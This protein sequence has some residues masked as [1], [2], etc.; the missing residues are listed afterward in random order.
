MSQ[1]LHGRTMISRQVLFEIFSR[2]TIGLVDNH[3]KPG[4]DRKSK[5]SQTD[6][7]SISIDNQWISRDND[8][9]HCLRHTRNIFLKTSYEYCMWMKTWLADFLFIRCLETW[10]IQ[11]TRIN[12]NTSV[13]F[14]DRVAG[15]F[16]RRSSQE[17][18]T[19]FIG[20]RF[21]DFVQSKINVSNSSS[22]PIT[23]F[24]RMSFSRSRSRMN[25]SCQSIIP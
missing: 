16:F 25:S 4:Q 19:S 17:K 22:C 7:S 3:M 8:H 6:C 12:F 13:N 11:L 1:T 14:I 2:M 5:A 20:N 9:H 23:P 21:N 18:D 24:R 15:K 10:R